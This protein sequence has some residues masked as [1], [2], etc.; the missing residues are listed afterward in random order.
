[1]NVWLA[2]INVE[3]DAGIMNLLDVVAKKDVGAVAVLLVITAVVGEGVARGK[4]DEPMTGP[5]EAREMMDLFSTVAG[6]ELE[7][8]VPLTESTVL[9]RGTKALDAMGKAKP[10]VDDGRVRL[11]NRD[12]IGL[13]ALENAEY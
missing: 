11:S 9:P 3:G 13:E 7:N 4:V 8:L 1:M 2:M 6:P 10:E 12:N 5:P